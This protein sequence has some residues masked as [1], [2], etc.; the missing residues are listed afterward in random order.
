MLCWVSFFARL[1]SRTSENRQGI[2]RRFLFAKI[3]ILR[4]DSLLM[5]IALP[6]KRFRIPLQG[7]RIAH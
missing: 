7:C 6:A 3:G 1:G 4:V 2:P 5:C